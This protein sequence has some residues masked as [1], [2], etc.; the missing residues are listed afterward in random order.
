[1]PW[2][3]EFLVPPSPH[4]DAQPRSSPAPRSL[5]SCLPETQW[6]GTQPLSHLT[7][8]GRPGYPDHFRESP[9]SWPSELLLM[10]QNPERG[11]VHEAQASAA[12][13]WTHPAPGLCVLIRFWG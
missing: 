1:M 13:L 3:L 9:D 4:L 11:A 12:S 8:V 7:C 5:G 2:T 6:P 10:P